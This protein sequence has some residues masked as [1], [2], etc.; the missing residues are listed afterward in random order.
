MNMNS[1]TKIIL[2]SM[3]ETAFQFNWSF[4]RGLINYLGNTK[5]WNRA[6]KPES[7]LWV[8]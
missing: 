8:S 7:D 5:D 2:V 6:W 1:I 3:E 4:P